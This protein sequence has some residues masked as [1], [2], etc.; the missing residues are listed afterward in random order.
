MFS[1]HSIRIRKLTAVVLAIMSV[2]MMMPAQAETTDL[3]VEVVFGTVNNDTYENPYLGLG[4]TLEGW[5]YYSDEELEGV[6]QRTKDALSDEL[7]D[8]IDQNIGLMMAEQPDGMRNVN[9]QIQNVKNY[10]SVY[11]TVGIQEVAVS[12]MSAYQKTLEAAGFTDIRLEVAEQNIGDKTF[13]CI[14]GQYIL[15]GAQIYFR[16][17]WDLRD[18]YVVTVTVTTGLEDKTEEVFSQF[19]LK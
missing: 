14:I 19:F 3:D 11:N 12:S 1:K 10:I 2:C 13:T 15:Q 17:I 9:I 18:I 6:N 5:H 7:D 16:Q 4:C 8:L